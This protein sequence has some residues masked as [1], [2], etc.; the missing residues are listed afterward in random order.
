MQ[1]VGY[2]IGIGLLA[3]I[4]LSSIDRLEKIDGIGIFAEW[5]EDER[6]IWNILP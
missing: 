3:K 4:I 2:N 5:S 1:P 6:T